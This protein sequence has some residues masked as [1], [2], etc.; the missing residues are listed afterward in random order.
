MQIQVLNQFEISLLKC[1]FEK[2]PQELSDIDA[3][4]TLR[5]LLD[6]LYNGFSRFDF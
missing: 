1:L 5:K 3:I 2:P 6:L 4:C